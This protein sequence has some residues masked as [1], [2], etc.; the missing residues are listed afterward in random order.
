MHQTG[1]LR[2]KFLLD[3][4]DISAVTLGDDRLLQIFLIGGGMDDL[5]QHLTRL[6]GGDPHFAADVGELSGR[7]VR[8]LVRADDTGGDPVAEVG[9]GVQRA[10]IAVQRGAH[11]GTVRVP[12]AYA[13]DDAQCARDREQLRGVQTAACLGTAQ[14]VGHIADPTEGRCAESPDQDVS[15]LGLRQ[16]TL[17]LIKVILRLNTERQLPCLVDGGLLR[18]HM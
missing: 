10:E 3:G 16:Q 11:A 4:D 1:D 7:A 5:V 15:I 17:D 18:Q 13:L 14:G 6:R 2:A 8:D 12:V 9:I